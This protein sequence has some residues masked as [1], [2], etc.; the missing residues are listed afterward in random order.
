MTI[1]FNELRTVLSRRF[2]LTLSQAGNL[3]EFVLGNDHL[4]GDV[5]EVVYSY[6][7]NSGEMPYGVAKAR[8]GDPA[9][10]IANH[11]AKEYDIK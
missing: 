4:A 3:L 5:E 10:W 7:I 11:L 8:T 2:D 6:F 1:H 9:Q